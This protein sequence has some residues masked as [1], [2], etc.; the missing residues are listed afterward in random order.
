MKSGTLLETLKSGSTCPH[1]CSCSKAIVF[2][3]CKIP[4]VGSGLTEF[5]KHFWWAYIGKRLYS[6]GGCIQRNFR[7]KR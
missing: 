4:N 6:G 3:Y 7:V 5:R 2:A 1:A